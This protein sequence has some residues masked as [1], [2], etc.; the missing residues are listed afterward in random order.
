MYS[1]LSLTFDSMF[2]PMASPVSALN[3]TNTSR[4][5][6]AVWV[7]TSRAYP[8]VELKTST[9][10]STILPAMFCP[11]MLEKV[12]CIAALFWFYSLELHIQPIHCHHNPFGR[13][14]ILNFKVVCLSYSTQKK[15]AVQ[16]TEHITK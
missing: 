16:S 14:S 13:S 4:P 7:E 11:E 15:F 12:A 2:I 5:V 3:L 8:L 9:I 1:S 6:T 10:P